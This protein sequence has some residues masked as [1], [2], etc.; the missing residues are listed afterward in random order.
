MKEENYAKEHW[1]RRP[2]KQFLAIG[3]GLILGIITTV[4]FLLI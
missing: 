3:I 4:A 2:D 1:K